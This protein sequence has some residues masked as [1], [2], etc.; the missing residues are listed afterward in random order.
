V[1]P[2]WDWA[3]FHTNYAFE[4]QRTAGH[5]GM[6]LADLLHV[7]IHTD[8]NTRYP[9]KEQSLAHAEDAA[10]GAALLVAG[11]TFHSVHGKNSTLFTGLELA[12]ARAHNVGVRSIP[13]TCQ[14]G[15]YRHRADLEGSTYL[16]VYQRGFN[17]ACIARIRP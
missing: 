5:N 7:P 1:L 9:D 13:L 10:A 11:V 15:A 8:E 14:R 17:D 4:W 6:E 12:A 3:E 16:R 2:V